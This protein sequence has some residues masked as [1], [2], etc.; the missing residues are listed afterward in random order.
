MRIHHRIATLVC[1]ILLIHGVARSYPRFKSNDRVAFIGDSITHGGMYLPYIQ[2]FYA[3]RFP[4]RNI[5]LLNLGIAGDTAKGGWE[6]CALEEEGLWESDVRSY[7]PTAAMIMFGMNDASSSI[8]KLSQSADEL[9]Q[10]IRQ[11][12]VWFRDSYGRM[13]DK[14]QALQVDSIGLITSSLYDQTMMNPEA[15]E[16]VMLYGVGKNDLIRRMSREVIDVE[17]SQRQLEQID[18]NTP[19]DAL[20]QKQQ[21]VDPAFS[22]IGNDRVH[23]G[24][25]GHMVMTYLFLKAQS[26]EG[27]VAHVEV[28]VENHKFNSVFNSSVKALQ[29]KKGRGLTFC[30]RAN[31]LPFPPMLYQSVD[32]LIPFGREFN[33]ECLSVKG[34]RAGQYALQVDGVLLGSFRADEWAEGINLAQFENAPQVLQARDVWHKCQERSRLASITRNVVWSDNQLRK[35]DGL[36]RSNLVACKSAVRHKLEADAS[37]TPYMKNVLQDYIDYVDQY[38][39]LRDQMNTLATQMYEH[40]QPIWRKIDIHSINEAF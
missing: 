27:A 31:S 1:L 17:A 24:A 6:R 38:E 30:Y 34:L 14:L 25:A 26:L 16:N 2:T 4:D 20:N 7:R 37:L 35:I 40:A 5:R 3:T 33:Q 13:L 18:F 39:S 29:V 11:H 9:E 23:P 36:D 32:A 15:R 28:D 19:M 21:M 12:I 8:F 10:K 22:I